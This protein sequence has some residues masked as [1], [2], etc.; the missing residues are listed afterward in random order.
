MGSS[1]RPEHRRRSLAAAAASAVALLA[2]G[3]SSTSDPG[4]QLGR[5]MNCVDDSQACVAERSMAL[6]QLHDDVGRA[7]IRQPASASAYASGVR[8]FAFKQKKKDLSCDE[9]AIGRREAEAG[10]QVLR[11]QHGAGLTTGQ[12]ARGVMLAQEVSKELDTEYKRR[13]KA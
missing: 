6:R 8:L 9:L 1:V 2:A 7:W 11:G 5:G 13:C 10:P 12:V 4:A 3:C